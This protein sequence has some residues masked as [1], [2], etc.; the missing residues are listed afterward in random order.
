M[1]EQAVTDTA[2]DAAKPAS[3]GVSELD[4]LLEEFNEPEPSPEVKKTDVSKSELREMIDTN[5]ADREERFRDASDKGI[6]E[7][8]ETLA[9]SLDLGFS[10][11]KNYKVAKGLLLSAAEDDLRVAKAFSNRT[12]NPAMWNEILDGIAKEF[13]EGRVD[14]NATGSHDALRQSLSKGGNTTTADDDNGVKLGKKL[15]AMSDADFAQYKS[16]LA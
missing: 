2:N 14:A 16:S 5:K 12:K 8:S 1:T 4:S 15:D 13:G 11:E 9:K 7:S 6:R 10:D 3:E